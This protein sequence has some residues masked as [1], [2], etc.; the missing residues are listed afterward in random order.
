MIKTI[1]HKGIKF[2]KYASAGSEESILK[3]I[4]EFWRDEHELE[5]IDTKKSLYKIIRP[6]SKKDLSK[7]LVI[8]CGKYWHFGR[9]QDI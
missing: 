1:E 6:E 2:E 9:K 4:N 3:L 8:N 7:W 5:I